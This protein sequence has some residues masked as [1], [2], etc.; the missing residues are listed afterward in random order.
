M[1][2]TKERIEKI[3]DEKIRPYLE[4]DGGGL[5]FVDF[6]EATGEVR[7]RLK[8]ACA[9]CAGAQMTL[10]MGVEAALKEEIPEVKRVVAV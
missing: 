6:D 8:G 5:E 9:G 1:S 2:D 3:I 10:S 7:V 4:A